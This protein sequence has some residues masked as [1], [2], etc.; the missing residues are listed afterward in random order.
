MT[1]FNTITGA[2]ADEFAWWLGGDVD[3]AE[4]DYW[5]TQVNQFY[6]LEISEKESLRAIMFIA[7]IG[8]PSLDDA[9]KYVSQKA[10]KEMLEK[11][12][13]K[14]V[15]KFL[16]AITKKA[17]KKGS[18]GVKK[19]AGKGIKG[20]MYEAKVVGKEGAYRLLGNIDDTGNIIWEVFEEVH[21]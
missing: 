7:S 12:G 16:K 20:F 17:A 19:L 2:A 14:G 15:K 3:R 5:L 21:K 8:M 13:E 1:C 6:E 18:N 11:V 9:F 10:S 4:R